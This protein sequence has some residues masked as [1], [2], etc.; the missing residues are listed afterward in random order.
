MT[1]QC[2]PHKVK[3]G[4]GDG[5]GSFRRKGRGQRRSPTPPLQ[6]RPPTLLLPAMAERVQDI[7]ATAPVQKNCKSNHLDHTN[8]TNPVIPSAP[9][10]GHIF[11]DSEDRSDLHFLVGR[12]GWRFPAHSFIVGKLQNTLVALLDHAQHPGNHAPEDTTGPLVLRLPDVE[13]EVFKQ[14]L[15]F[16]YTDQTSFSSVESTL[17]LLRAS[18]TFHLPQLTERCL[19]HL[20][21][22]LNINNV[23]LILSHLV[24][25]EPPQK[26]KMSAGDCG[27]QRPLS[28]RNSEK[29][30]NDYQDLFSMPSGGSSAQ[31]S[32][33]ASS[34][35]LPSGTD[36][37]PLPFG[38]YPTQLPF[39]MH[40][41]QL[42]SGMHPTQQSSGMHP[43]QQS[44]EMH[45]TQLSSGMHPTQLSSGMHPTQ[46]SSGMHPT[47]QSSGMHPT[48]L[49]SGMHPTQ[50][51]SGRSANESV[52]KVAGSSLARSVSENGCGSQTLRQ[53]ATRSSAV[54]FAPVQ[55]SIQA[56]RVDASNVAGEGSRPCV[57]AGDCACSQSGENC[58]PSCADVS[59]WIDN[60]RNELKLRCFQL[61]DSHADLVLASEAFETLEHPLLT[62]ILRRDSLAVTSEPRVFDALMRWASCACKRT[63]RKL[64]P[65]NKCAVLGEALLTVRYLT[66]TLED[67]LRG[68]VAQGV[69]SRE[70][71]EFFLTRL[72]N[73][74]SEPLP[75]RWR[76][77]KVGVPRWKRRSPDRASADLSLVEVQQPVVKSKKKSMS[78]KLL[79]GM[80]DLVICVIQL[81]D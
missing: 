35:Q 59:C 76:D 66:M 36:P 48:Q 29:E 37:T 72:T 43:T 17:Q 42:S 49:S 25:P 53:Q 64:T 67:F 52:P 62:D 7:T 75:E 56:G 14:M 47:Q 51:S 34:I 65:E 12:D 3:R 24:S 31:E 57:A 27:K 26:D 4:A 30:T 70:D 18:Q 54:T 71:K 13:P 79:N 68:P 21:A 11:Y 33:R 41:T 20:S 60:V 19:K 80:G 6:P 23:L 46:L 9:S 78:K 69:L 5:G 81:L 58:F 1:E 77:S 2:L 8:P 39:G 38:I 74:S 16:I 22:S 45:P 55:I 44:S 10:P 61:V 40:P 32:S 50:L 15:R 63:Q 73:R 28:G